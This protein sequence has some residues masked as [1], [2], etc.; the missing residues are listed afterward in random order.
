[1]KP[2]DQYKSVEDGSLTNQNWRGGG[3]GEVLTNQNWRGGGGGGGH[4]GSIEVV[5]FILEIY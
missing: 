4:F 2:C 3:G 5:F 1:L